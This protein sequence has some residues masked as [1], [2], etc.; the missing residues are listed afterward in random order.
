MIAAAPSPL[1][2]TRELPELSVWA[3]AGAGADGHRHRWPLPAPSWACKAAGHNTGGLSAAD[4][5]ALAETVPTRV[6]D[7]AYRS[8]KIRKFRQITGNGWEP[9]VSLLFFYFVAFV[10]FFVSLLFF[11][12][13]AELHESKFPFV[14]RIEFIRSKLS[15]CS[16]HVSG[17]GVGRGSDV[18]SPDFSRARDTWVRY[19]SSPNPA[20]RSHGIATTVCGNMAAS[21]GTA[22]WRSP[23]PPPPPL[24]CSQPSSLNLAHNVPPPPPPLLPT[25]ISPSHRW[26]RDATV[27]F[28]RPHHYFTKLY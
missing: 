3:G 8:R 2:V 4:Q 21:A 22:T 9:A 23:N 14:S 5:P 12:F 17:A 19:P 25:K 13:V 20:A 7:P 1:R 11:Y 18:L 10:A 27:I 28:F 24:R 15:N 26:W 16:A 6:G